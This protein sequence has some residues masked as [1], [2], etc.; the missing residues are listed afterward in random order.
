[1]RI[2][3]DLGHAARLLVKTPAIALAAVLSLALGTGANTAIFGVINALMLRS[4]AVDHPERLVKI[5]A[6]DPLHPQHAQELLLAMLSEIRNSGAFASVSAWLGGS[7]SNF[8]VNG[9]RYSGSLDTVSEDYFA[10]LN[11]RPALGRLLTSGDVQAAVISYGCWQ[12]RF[13]GDPAVI[14]KS[15][16]IDD[17][18]LTIVGVAPENFTGLMIDIAPEATV[19]IGYRGREP[20]YRE[21]RWYDVIARLKPNSTLAQARARIEAQWPSLLRSTAPDIFHGA[22]RAAFFALRGSVEPAARGNSYLRERLTK[23]LGVLMALAGAVLL[24]TCVNVANL[25]L[26]RAAARRHEFAIRVALGAPRWPLVRMMLAEAL[27]LASTGAFLG[28]WM[29]GFT[30]RFL[31][32]SFWSGFVPLVLDPSPDSRVLAFTAA[33]AAITALLFGIAPGW[34]MSAWDPSRWLSQSPRTTSGHNRRFG[35]AL[36]AVQAGLALILLMGATLFVRSLRN[37]ETVD[38]GYRRDHMLALQ[39]FPIAGRE[40]IP[41]RALYLEDVVRRMSALDGVDSA[42]YID[43]GPATQY[44]YTT[45]VSRGAGGAVRRVVEERVGPGLFKLIGMRVLAGRE[46]NWRDDEKAERVAIVSESLA[47]A[48]FPDQNPIGRKIDAGAD[49]DHHVLRIVGVVNSASLWRLDSVQPLAVYYC[50]LQSPEYNQARLILKTRGAPGALAVRA[51]HALEAAGYH[52]SLRTV[53][54]EQRMDEALVIEKMIAMLA[55]GFGLLALTLAAAGLYGVL[56]YS[57]S[58]R[59]REIG[60]RMALG[61][62][63]ANVLSMIG[64]EALR[65]VALGMAIAIPLILMGG[66]LVAAMLFGVP[67]RSPGSMLVSCAI[68]LTVAAM[69][70]FLPAWRASRVDPMIALR[71]E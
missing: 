12:H 69:A 14:G 20:R 4:L 55:S 39:M 10:T 29:A 38:P 46:F 44:E 65:S 9:V 58:M 68:L 2:L 15:I 61:A 34:R 6:L 33:L 30:A 31:L 41:N 24:I 48:L 18:P 40:H 25:L 21:D 50:L 54:I 62:N 13:A 19:P 56:S 22:K 60:L 51:E 63:R 47:R 49:P 70:S 43:A 3:S 57:V 26:A 35:N 36:V 11:V 5:G 53:T 1:M 7:M 17:R 71:S 66:K 59:D 23:P 32:R 28:L 42:S 52:Y 45:P 64:R 8:E 37:L 27:L 16:R 67:A